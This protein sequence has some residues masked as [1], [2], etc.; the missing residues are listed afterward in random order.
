MQKYDY[1]KLLGR[2]KE[3]GFTQARLAKELGMS[4][5]SI[6]FSLNNK[7]NFRQDEILEV[8]NILD[9]PIGEIETYF[10]DHKL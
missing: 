9:I 6:N 8:S 4:E 1:S 7:R 10:F 3:Y 2:M 5:C